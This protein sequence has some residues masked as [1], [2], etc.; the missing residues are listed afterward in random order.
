[1]GRQP[2][3]SGFGVVGTIVEQQE[4]KVSELHLLVFSDQYIVL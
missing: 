4:T 3:L 1:V 2:F